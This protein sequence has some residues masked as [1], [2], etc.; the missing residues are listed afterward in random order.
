MEL[1]EITLDD[2]TREF[3][4]DDDIPQSAHIGEA[5]Y[6]K[7]CGDG[8][9]PDKR[10]KFCDRHQGS[11]T[12]ARVSS[13]SGSRKRNKGSASDNELSKT[14]AKVLI[15]L[16]VC[17]AWM[18]LRRYGQADPSGDIAE[19]L[20]MTDEEAE[21]IS[22]PIARSFNSTSTGARYGKAIV[23]NTDLIDA[24]I[25][26]YEYISRMNRILDSMKTRRQPNDVA[27]E[28]HGGQNVAPQQNEGGGQEQQPEYSV[29]HLNA[30]E[31]L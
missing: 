29:R 6:C 3:D 12:I 15:L 14:F 4:D 2:I 21:A 18:Q 19:Q 8:P 17:I 28:R 24:G 1:E 25:G 5:G 10:R 27:Q 23:D 31:S 13:G 16:T 9:L 7:I 20:A 11:K 26:M 30:V 22:R